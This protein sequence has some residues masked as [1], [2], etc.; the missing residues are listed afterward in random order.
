MKNE[1]LKEAMSDISLFVKTFFTAL[2]GYT[3]ESLNQNPYKIKELANPSEELQLI[4]IRKNPEVIQY[5]KHPTTKVQLEVIRTSQDRKLIEKVEMD[6]VKANPEIIAILPNPSEAIQLEA[7]KTDPSVISKI[8][9]LSETIQ[10]TAIQKSIY[11]IQNI[12]NPTPKVLFQAIKLSS[13]DPFFINILPESLQI[14]AVQAKPNIFSLI[15]DPSPA[16]HKAIIENVCNIKIHT[17]VDDGFIP[18]AKTLLYQLYSIKHKHNEMSLTANY[19]D[20]RQQAWQGQDKADKWKDTETNKAITNFK[21]N[22]KKDYPFSTKNTGDIFLYSQ[23]NTTNKEPIG[24]VS[25]Y[26]SNGEVVETIEYHNAEEYLKRIAKELDYN[27]NG[28]EY[29]TIV[30]DAKL[31]KSIDDLV[32]NV[33]GL[34]NPHNLTWYEQKKQVIQS[35]ESKSLISDV[36]DKHSPRNYHIFDKSTG[37]TEP[38]NIGDISLDKQHPESIKELLSGKQVKMTNNSGFSQ[39]VGLSKTPVGWGIQIGKQAFS[40]AESSAEI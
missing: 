22:I 5:I 7:V 25:F 3:P 18:K 16:V 19:A 24:K 36:S 6:M 35:S 40:A 1:R 27:P 31:I 38:L 33:Y 21:E 17:N 2:S 30:N 39:M 12:P 13:N 29:E 34:D 37:K 23:T 15:T 32:Y 20:D 28:F 14:T 10:L 8:K 9:D 4:A 11:S 26:G